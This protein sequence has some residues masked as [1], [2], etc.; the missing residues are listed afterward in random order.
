[1]NKYSD[2]YINSYKIL[3]NAILGFEFECYFDTSFYKVLELLNND[4]RPVKVH[5][6]RTYHSELRP[7]AN[8][9]KLERDFS[10]GENMAEI[11]TGPLDYYS[12]KYY[13]IKLLKFIDTYGH[14]TN[15]CSLHI[16]LSFR[17][18]NLS[19]L[20]I[21]RQILTVDEEDVYKKFPSREKNIYAK[22]VENIIPF[23]D[24]DYSNISIGTIGNVLKIPDSKYYGINFKHVNA[25]KDQR[26]EFRY[27]G[28][29]DY[30]KQTGDIL[31]IMDKMIVT[32][33]NNISTGFDIEDS[34][35]LNDFLDSKIN[36]FKNLSTYDDFLVE[37]PNLQLQV[38]MDG[39]YEVVSAHYSKLYNRLFSLLESVEGLDSGII[40]YYVGTNKI[41][42]VNANFTA[43]LDLNRYDFI[44]CEIYGGIFIESSI[45]NCNIINSEIQRSKVSKSDITDVSLI[46]CNVEDSKLKRCFFQAG[47]LNAHME[48]GIF[49]SGK[50]GPYATF[51]NDVIVVGR[52]EENFFKT[53]YDEDEEMDDKSKYPK[54]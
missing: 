32:T 31:E 29:E 49:R 35:K 47:L 16:N 25:D 11:V 21:L 3:S 13:L 26:L 41:E 22:S 38:D 6:F 2:K 37:Y 53:K 48:G 30:Q 34:E 4:L 46:S 43:F 1:M 28:G 39:M 23:K 10:G 50:I 5:G 15:K 44:N 7:D 9:F 18:K 27:I 40:N 36:V 19:D 24:Y 8:N 54:K 33:Y 45:Y 12:A 14:T 51:D 20:N 17:D 52:E 42:I